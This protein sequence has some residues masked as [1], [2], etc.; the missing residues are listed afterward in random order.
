MSANV[1]LIHKGGS[2]LRGAEQCVLSLLRNVKDN[3]ISPVLICTNDA[4]LKEARKYNVRA[5]QFDIHEIMIDGNEKTLPLFGFLKSMWNLGR[6]LKREKIS[7]I[8]C[9]GGLPCQTAV[10]VAKLFGIPVL[11]HFHH[12]ASKRYYYLWLV[13]Y[14]DQVIFPSK[15]SRDH[16]Y[17]K[18]G[19]TGDVVLNGIDTSDCRPLETRDFVLRRSLGVADTDVV[20]GQVGAFVK[21]K[22]HDVLLAA[23]EVACQQLDNLR[24]ILVGEGPER[25]R[26]EEMSRN[27]G[28][29]G[30]VVFTGYVER[31]I[32][33][34]QQ[35]IDINV[36]ASVE[37][38]LGLVL[39]QGS[40]CGLPNIGADCTG[41]REAIRDNET[42]FLFREDDVNELAARIVE[43]AKE[44]EKR[45]LMGLKGRSYI[46]SRFSEEEYATRIIEKMLAMIE[47]HPSGKQGA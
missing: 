25:K 18:A 19:I 44:P 45:K 31:A 28:L 4:L 35:V 13:N 1:L 9:S 15:Y 14:V 26:I 27:R 43:L 32:D 7:L 20:I 23:F 46:E 34:F 47:H 24:L 16:S 11:C 37:E 41:I 5:F 33:Y 42:G 2:Q 40:A 39:L 17:S 21:L 29:E 10:L 12:P 30:R 3:Q 36:L 38:G 22:R 6:I 8:Y